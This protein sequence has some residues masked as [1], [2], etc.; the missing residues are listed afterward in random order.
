[1]RVGR[2]TEKKIPVDYL[3][4]FFKKNFIFLVYTQWQCILSYDNS[5][6]MFKF[7]KTLHPGG[8]WTRHLL[9][10][11]RTRWPLCHAAK[12][13]TSQVTYNIHRYIPMNVSQQLWTGT[14]YL[15]LVV[16]GRQTADQ[17]VFRGKTRSLPDL[18]EIKALGLPSWR[19]RGR[20]PVDAD[21]K[22]IFVTWDRKSS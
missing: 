11:R 21:V 9:F 20:V 2:I 19:R 6:A 17:I 16:S 5:T 14:C 12:A 8:I 18:Q 1:M 15:F 13:L 3:T 10:C 7:L 4:S 22:N